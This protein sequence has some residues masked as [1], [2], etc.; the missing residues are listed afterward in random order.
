MKMVFNDLTSDQPTLTHFLPPTINRKRKGSWIQCFIE[1][2]VEVACRMGGTTDI[3]REN[4]E[5]FLR[6][7][8]RYTELLKRYG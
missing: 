4:A 2:G 1:A 5:Y 6:D 7:A 8:K 3:S